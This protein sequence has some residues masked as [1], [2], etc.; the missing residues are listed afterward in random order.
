M[1]SIT[2]SFSVAKVDVRCQVISNPE[3]LEIR[4]PKPRD[5]SELTAKNLLERD[6]E[7]LTIESPTIYYPAR[8]VFDLDKL[9]TNFH[10]ESKEW[11]T[12]TCE[13]KPDDDGSA[14]VIIFT[15]Q[16]L[17]AADHF[18]RACA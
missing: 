15:R 13:Q 12:G 18:A 5:Q 3:S 4:I 17:E 9:K 8:F 1:C 10:L 6:K 14:L 2:G 11:I 7:W 16:F